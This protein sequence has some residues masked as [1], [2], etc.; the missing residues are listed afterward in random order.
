DD[1]GEQTTTLKV[2][3]KSEFSNHPTLGD[4]IMEQSVQVIT[5]KVRNET[6]KTTIQQATLPSTADNDITYERRPVSE[7]VK[8][9]EVVAAT[10]T[11]N[12]NT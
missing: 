8:N 5:V 3:T 12:V 4:K 2:I 7:L 10:N 1:N 6:I 9:F 11:N